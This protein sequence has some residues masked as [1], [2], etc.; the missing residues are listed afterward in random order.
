MS[1]SC[2]GSTCPTNSSGGLNFSDA[3]SS[4]ATNVARD[5]MPRGTGAE[6]PQNACA[7]QP[8]ATHAPPAHR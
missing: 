7:N 8:S 5:V 1:T 3:T 4:T 2:T 6:T